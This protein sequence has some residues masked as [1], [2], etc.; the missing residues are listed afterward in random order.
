MKIIRKAQAGSW[1]DIL[2]DETGNESGYNYE[3]LKLL[4]IKQRLDEKHELLNRYRQEFDEAVA[5]GLETTNVDEYRKKRS[6][7]MST[8][9]VYRQLRSEFKNARLQLS[10]DDDAIDG[11][12][13]QKF[14]LIDDPATEEFINDTYSREDRGGEFAGDMGS[15]DFDVQDEEEKAWYQKY[16]NM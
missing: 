6:D 7:L 16:R 1:E 12:G 8:I 11:F 13:L 9:R 14:E 2:T 15:F 10:H 5:N 3:Q 4:D